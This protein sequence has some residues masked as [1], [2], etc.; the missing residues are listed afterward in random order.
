ME[1]KYSKV[2]K[3]L[4]NRGLSNGKIKS[5]ITGKNWAMSIVI[6]NKQLQP[7]TEHKCIL[8]ILYMDYT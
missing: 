8:Y 2:I 6:T 4:N 1:T 5:R 7:T 3:G